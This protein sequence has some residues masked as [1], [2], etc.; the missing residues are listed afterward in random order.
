MRA[1]DYSVFKIRYIK[2]PTPNVFR[3]WAEWILNLPENTLPKNVFISLLRLTLLLLQT[4][5]QKYHSRDDFI[6]IESYR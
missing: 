5:F 1:C 4:A 2:Q 3:Q 6:E